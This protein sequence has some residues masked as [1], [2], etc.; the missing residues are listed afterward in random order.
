MKPIIRK[1]AETDLSEVARIYEAIHTAE[2][3]GT[4]T[5]GWQRGVYPTADTAVSSLGKG[6]L[7]VLEDEGKIKA[8]ARIN[9]E[10]VDVYARVHWHTDAPDTEVMV[11]HTLTVDPAEAHRGYGKAFAAFYEE[12]ALS[13]GCRYLRI[14]TNARNRAARAFYASIG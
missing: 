2:E 5:T 11:L 6:E 14:D 4:L 9:R 12:Y 1:A 7:F 8:S 3:A 10:Q 13:H